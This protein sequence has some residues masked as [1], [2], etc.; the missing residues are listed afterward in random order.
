MNMFKI[1]Q[2]GT[3]KKILCLGLM[4]L[5]GSF[6]NNTVVAADVQVGLAWVGK[7]GMANRVSEGFVAEVAE[8]APQI[9]LEA[10]KDLQSLDALK[11][12]V[13][14]FQKEKKAMVI[15]RSNGAEWLGK[16]PP[17]LPTFI[18]GCNH[19]KIL[20]AVQN[21]ERPE[22]NIT[23]VT[24]Y[25]PVTSQFDVFQAILPKMDSVLLLMGKGNPSAPIDQAGTK[26]VCAKRNIKYK[27]VMA[28]SREEVLKAVAEHKDKVSA[29]I[30]GNQALVIDITKDIM[31]EAGKTPVFSYSSEPV[32]DG[33]LGGFV[34]D[35]E[36]LGRMLAQSLVDVVVKGMAIGTVPVKVD[37]KPLFY[38]NAKTAQ[39]IGVEVPFEILQAATVVE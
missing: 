31:A 15:L 28:E 13:D 9:K 5:M 25:L 19:P 11:E 26:E 39:K 30:I 17:A 10:Q 2:E 22:G 37:P 36:K 4:V 33:A 34:A 32:K 29:M 27:E 20:G 24:Y 38:V 1:N 7:S 16:N 14:R 8:L 23:G 12:V 35:D 3:M 21:L 6:L 18:G